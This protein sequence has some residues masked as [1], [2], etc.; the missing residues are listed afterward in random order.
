[1]TSSENGAS[2]HLSWQE[3]GFPAAMGV[4]SDI[5]SVG[6]NEKS[7]RHRHHTTKDTID[8]VANE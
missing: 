6:L 1:M 4:E 7:P 2:D 5:F 3:F 8:K